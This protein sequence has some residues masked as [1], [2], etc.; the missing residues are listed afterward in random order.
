MGYEINGRPFTQEDLDDDQVWDCFAVYRTIVVV[1]GE[2]LGGIYK[3]WDDAW[4][5]ARNIGRGLGQDVAMLT[6]T[7]LEDQLQD[8]NRVAFAD[9]AVREVLYA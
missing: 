8:D 1:D 9:V 5:E 6:R 7:E 3:E 2:V 4:E